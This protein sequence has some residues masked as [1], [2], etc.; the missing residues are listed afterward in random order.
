MSG[1]T[2][3]IKETPES[4]LASFHHVRTSKKIAIY[5][6]ESRSSSDTESAGALILN[7]PASRTIRNECL[8]FKPPGVWDSVTAVRTREFHSTCHF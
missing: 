4:S 2:V 3:F 1:V 8:L 7:F 5:E 6:S